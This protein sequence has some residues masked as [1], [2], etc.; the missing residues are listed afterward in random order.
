VPRGT[1]PEDVKADY[2]DGVLTVSVPADGSAE[3]QTIP[4]RH[5]EPP[6]E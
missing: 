1:K 2:V 6:A 3:P 5:R 4:V